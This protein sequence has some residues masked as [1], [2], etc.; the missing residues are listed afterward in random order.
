MSLLQEYAAVLMEI[1]NPIK[2]KKADIKK[3]VYN[4]ADLS[5]VSELIKKTCKEHGLSVFQEITLWNESEGWQQVLVTRLTDGQEERVL[6]SALI[7]NISDPQAL[8]SFITYMRRY[9]LLASFGM[10]PEDD[11]GK[12]AKQRVEVDARLKQAQERLKA[13]ERHYCQKYE[14]SNI[15]E[16]HETMI[17]TRS[18]YRN[19]PDSLNRIANELMEG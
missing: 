17:M 3:Y 11:D 4:Y 18:D 5:Q 10:A 16:F 19:D 1:E 8:G 6:S 14:Y 2:D 12:A 7:P 13:A 9:Q 15:R